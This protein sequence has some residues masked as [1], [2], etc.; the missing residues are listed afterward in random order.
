MSVS[1]ESNTESTNEAD[2][3]FFAMTSHSNRFSF[4]LSPTEGATRRTF[5]TWS[6]IDPPRPAPRPYDRT[7]PILT[8]SSIGR[9]LTIS[10][11]S[12]YA[13]IGESQAIIAL[14]WPD[15]DDIRT[16]FRLTTWAPSFFE[17]MFC[18]ASNDQLKKI[19]FEGHFI[20][21]VSVYK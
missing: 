7:S 4:Q 8:L 17:W 16:S 13:Q 15:N 19:V 20:W 2:V 1:R 3:K 12:N 18:E 5:D 6:K 10:T 9:R 14:D 11:C 21:I